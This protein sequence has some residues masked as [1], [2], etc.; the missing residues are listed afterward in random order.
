[1]E[2]ERQEA[3]KQ[4][5]QA[6]HEVI[7]LPVFWQRTLYPP[8]F[9]ARLR[10][11]LARLLRNRRIELIELTRGNFEPRSPFRLPFEVVAVG[12]LASRA[13][14]RLSDRSWV[15][16]PLS[17]E[18]GI[19]IGTMSWPEYASS[20]ARGGMDIVVSDSRSARDLMRVESRRAN[21]ERHP[22][23]HVVLN[24]PKDVRRD[25]HVALPPGV[26]MVVAPS[27]DR[28][29]QTAKF[30][31]G[32]AAS[33]VHNLPLHA[34]VATAAQE[35]KLTELRAPRIRADP[36]TN[37][38][39]SMGDAYRH[40]RQR[41]NDL[42]GSRMG[43]IEGR[44]RRSV[45][46]HLQRIVPPARFDQESDA[47]VP[48]TEMTD[49]LAKDEVDIY[50][51]LRSGAIDV[52]N[53]PRAVDIALDRLGGRAGAQVARDDPSTVS[54]TTS[55]RAGELYLVRVEIGRVLVG[56]LFKSRPPAI[57]AILPETQG[58][59]H[60]IDVCVFGLDFECESSA[61]EKR[62][63]PKRGPM[64]AATFRV[65]APGASEAIRRL[66]VTISHLDNVLQS[67]IVTAIVRGDE[68]ELRQRVITATLEHAS[69]RRFGNLSSKQPRAAAFV[70]NDDPAG[71]HTLSL[72]SGASAASVNLDESRIQ[73]VM[74]KF[75]ENLREAAGDPFPRFPMSVPAASTPELVKRKEDFAGVVRALAAQGAELRQGVFTRTRKAQFPLL[76]EIRETAGKTIQVVQVSETLLVP[77][78]ILYDFDVDP[79]QLAGLPVCNGFTGTNACAHGPKSDDVVCVRGF[80]GIRH[81]LEQLIAHREEEDLA[82]V[83]SGQS[84]NPLV[85]ELWGAKTGKPTKVDVYTQLW[86]DQT[87]ARLLLIQGHL[88]V[89]V[90]SGIRERIVDL[91]PKVLS[92]FLVT[93]QA[94]ASEWKDP[95]SIVLLL[96]CESAVVPE[97]ALIG[98]ATAFAS[99]G[100]GAV[101]G[102]EER[103]FSDFC[104]TIGKELVAGL[105]GPSG[106]GLGHALQGIRAR[107]LQEYNPLAFTLTAFGSADLK[108]AP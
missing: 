54:V 95:H 56:S 70:V 73:A 19:H 40:V 92:H 34:A 23:V 2:A 81:V 69:T 16:A 27:A 105:S 3:E 84:T 100:A 46:A 42:Y 97:D 108:V 68:V 21:P 103:V 66:R 13:V 65:R 63:L 47:F 71:T 50:G 38:S 78:T 43:T 64:Q 72:K 17:R 22:R 58:D 57:D 86:P 107:L 76:R 15:K 82:E 45:G 87:R 28:P 33:L 11:D 79:A 55:L 59:G 62:W 74:R 93:Q 53:A 6:W 94:M 90:Q 20:R 67:F 52:L 12:G 18:H 9:S 77:W 14:E 85:I 104:E 39:L 35:A 25:L 80:W 102:T 26:G 36:A 89:R 37:W 61:V 5:P 44:F 48:L 83:V 7:A 31:E 60:W 101:V 51:I 75:R 99:A 30:I 10:L 49:A 4:S 91:E 41:A 106:A 32:L 98:M 88:S 96:A 1:V 29:E 8:W 24:L